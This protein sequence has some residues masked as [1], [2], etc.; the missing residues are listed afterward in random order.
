MRKAPQAPKRFKSSYILFFL[1]VQ[2]RIKNE[3]GKVSA[4]TVSKKASELWKALSAKE[5]WHWDSEAIKEKERYT[6]EKAIYTGPW[7][8]IYKRTKKNPTAPK[9]NPS[10][11]LLFSSSKRQDIKRLNPGMKNTKVSGVLGQ[12]WR[13]MPTEKKCYYVERER[14]EREQYKIDTAEWKKQQVTAQLRAKA[15]GTTFSSVDIAECDIMTK[16]Q[17]EC[18]NNGVSACAYCRHRGVNNCCPYASHDPSAS[19][20][21]RD[22]S[23][24][25]SRMAPYGQY[26]Y[27]QYPHMYLEYPPQGQHI[28]CYTQDMYRY[29]SISAN[30][31]PTPFPYVYGLS[32]IEE[33]LQRMYHKVV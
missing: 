1:H 4:P 24:Y 28:N 22:E 14:E 31:N 18:L 2:K 20:D 13:S 6:A 30:G 25:L 17:T 27:H 5:R 32:H 8:V 10:A 3:L 15:S 33:K 11:F 29:N 19:Q 23:T 16:T 12:L 21:N 9:R 7:Q 26:Q